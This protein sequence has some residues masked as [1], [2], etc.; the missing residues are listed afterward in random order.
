MSAV[1]SAIASAIA[2][3]QQTDK[4]APRPQTEPP[5]KGKDIRRDVIDRVE[6]VDTTEAADAVKG[7]AANDRED[8]REDH[9][10]QGNAA[11]PRARLDIEG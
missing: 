5:K 1:P 6:L 3:I 2:N 9:E 11:P 7:L 4:V 10:A 8:A